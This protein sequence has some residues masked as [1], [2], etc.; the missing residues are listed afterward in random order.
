MHEDKLRER[1]GDKVVDALVAQLRSGEAPEIDPLLFGAKLAGAGIVVEV[2]SL[3]DAASEAVLVARV[4]LWRC[5][6]PRCRRLIDS[7]AVAN[8]HCP[9]CGSASRGTDAD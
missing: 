9:A 5:P 1:F 3:L 2:N 4:S 8:R 6:E 7:D